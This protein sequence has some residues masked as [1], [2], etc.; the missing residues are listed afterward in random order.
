MTL[1]AFKWFVAAV[2]IVSFG[3]C[4]SAQAPDPG[5]S[6]FLSSCASCHGSDAK[7]DGPVAAVLK[8]RPADLTILAKKNGGVFPVEKVYRVIDGREEVASH[9]SREM[10]IW[11]YRFV[12]PSA[13]NL[14]M[15]DDYILLP[16]AS[17]EAIVHSR[18]LAMID[19]LSRVQEK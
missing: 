8:Q 12:P 7:G 1:G 14:Q 3:A 9:G 2:A 4:A 17:A 5:K 16:P 19:Y 11:G 18:I 6:E 10:P 13:K 15:A